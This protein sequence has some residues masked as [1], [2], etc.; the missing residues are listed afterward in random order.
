MR[1]GSAE[2]TKAWAQPQEKATKQVEALKARTNDTRLSSAFYLL[3][4]LLRRHGIAY[5]ES[6]SGT[7][8]QISAPILMA[9]DFCGLAVSVL[10]RAFSAFPYY[11]APLGCAPGS[12]WRGAFRRPITYSQSHDVMEYEAVQK[13]KLQSAPSRICG[14]VH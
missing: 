14:T 9:R 8:P 1:P 13:S 4:L 5:N 11:C 2:T 3:R 12:H 6:I 7:S 10:S